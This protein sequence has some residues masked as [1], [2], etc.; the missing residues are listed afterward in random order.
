[1]RFGGQKSVYGSVVQELKRLIASGALKAGEKLPSVRA[2]AFERGI[3]PNTVQRAY[4]QLEEEGL[5]CIYPKKGAFVAGN[6]QAKGKEL[7]AIF[8]SLKNDGFS[9]EEVK[10]AFEEVY[11]GEDNACD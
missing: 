3:N 8:T 9:L 7:K 11:R 4:L 10:R 2:L 5:I 1:M 6:N